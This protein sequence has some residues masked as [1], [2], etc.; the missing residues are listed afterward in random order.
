MSDT[1]VVPTNLYAAADWLRGRHPWLDQIALRIAGHSEEWLDELAGAIL[2]CIEHG[3]AWNQYE[4]EHPKPRDRD[5]EAAY[6]R[7]ENAAP[8]NTPRGRAY[9]VMSGGE[10]RMVRLV[11]TLANVRGEDSVGG[12]EYYRY[13][14]RVPWSVH[15][16]SGWD[17]R[18]VAILE[19]WF[20]IVRAQLG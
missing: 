12:G 11:A 2:D 16:V 10:A 13:Q 5:D 9:A 15:D 6:D 20:R 19:D 4:R 1:D 18:G 17:D 7:W 14:R 3:E 8:K